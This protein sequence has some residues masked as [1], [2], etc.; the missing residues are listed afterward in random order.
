MIATA[1]GFASPRPPRRKLSRAV[2]I[3]IGV[4][5]ALHAGAL[6]YLAA[7]RFAPTL[8]PAPDEG[9][10]PIV[11]KTYRPPEPPKPEPEPV[12]LDTPP[13]TPP[14]SAA[15]RQ[16]DLPPVTFDVP[17]APFPPAPDV[18]VPDLPPIF[19]P[20]PVPAPLAPVVEAPPPGRRLIGRPD[21]LT[22][23][24]GR[25][26]ADAYPKRA[27]EKDLSGSATLACSVTASGA[28][29]GCTVA[30]EA[31]A[32]AGFGAAALKLSRHF[33]MKPR[34]EDGLPVDGGVVRIPVSFALG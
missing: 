7:A 29:T 16:P 8:L 11:V 19:A 22:R 23:P 28:L 6:L 32:G 13:P 33:R 5:V 31:P 27:L 26:L 34:T 3:G 12:K 24:N 1:S 20:D 2:S 4:S 9:R 17:A 18:E 25:Q 21:W 15:P 10:P 30:E 14:P